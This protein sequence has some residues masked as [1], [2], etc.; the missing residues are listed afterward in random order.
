MDFNLFLCKVREFLK[1][2]LEINPNL[3][4]HIDQLR[5][6]NSLGWQPSEAAEM[7]SIKFD[8]VSV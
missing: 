2:C 6:W 8:I 1:E 5:T 4:K 7:L 3:E